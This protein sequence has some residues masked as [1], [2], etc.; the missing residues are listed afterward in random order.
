VRRGGLAILAAITGACA[1]GG[2]KPPAAPKPKAAPAAP[3]AQ[4]AKPNII[5]ILTDDLDMTHV[6]YMPQL[7]RLLVEKGTTFTNSFVTYAVCAPSRASILTGQYA[8]NH[9]VLEGRPPRGSFRKFHAEGR[10]AS[11]IA[12]WLRAAGYRTGLLGKYINYY[13]LQRDQKYVPPGWDDW[14][15]YFDTTS[16]VEGHSYYGYQ[17]NENGTVVRYGEDAKDYLT[18]VLRDKALDFVARTPDGQPFFLYLAEFAPHA[19][20]EA[21][22]R[23]ESLFPDLKAPR[24]PN[25]DEEDVSD[26]PAWVKALPRLTPE[27]SKA[28]DEAFRVRVQAMQA[29]DETIAALVKAL[30]A[31]GMLENTYIFFTSD[32]GYEFGGHRMDH[33]KGD[34]YEESIRVP[35]IVRGPEVPQNKSEP[36][37]ALNIDLAP[38]F[39]TIAGADSPD[40]V[41]GRSLLRLLQGKATFKDWRDDFLV[42]LYKREEGGITEYAALRTTQQLYVEYASGE[43]ELYDV[44]K[45]PYELHNLQ[46][47]ADPE[48]LARLAARLAALKACAGATCR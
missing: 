35:L 46:A 30:A 14:R 15:G 31:R 22:E 19:R 13:P 9:G 8:H 26:K 40:T 32:N 36:S 1:G 3:R 34:A 12:T 39:A 25:Y 28:T 27:I 2:P 11:T 41:D 29:V 20:V 18:D 5:L 6:R 42:E 4:A 47:S 23:H 24:P 10:E 37:I 48:L 43:R 38:T 33:G 7:K 45:D 21:A 17:I 16:A 44:V